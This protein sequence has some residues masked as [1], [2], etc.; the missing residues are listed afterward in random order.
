M[1]WQLCEQVPEIIRSQVVQLCG[2]RE[3]VDHSARPGAFYRIMEHPVLFPDTERPDGALTCRIVYRDISV[4]EE[5]A[6]I[7]FLVHAV[8]QAVRG[9]A[10]RRNS[11]IFQLLFYP[12]K[13]FLNKRLYAAL[14]LL[15]PFLRWKVP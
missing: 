10:F 2:F 5:Y 6:K 1:I 15:E 7:F 12:R 14:P 4:S 3:T 8:A 9:L 13:I 11:P